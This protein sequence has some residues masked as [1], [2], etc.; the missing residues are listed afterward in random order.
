MLTS[1]KEN[2]TVVKDITDE[3]AKTLD[4]AFADATVLVLDMEAV[5]LGR[6]GNVSLVSIAT[7]THCYLFD[8]LDC[9]SITDNTICYLKRL[10]EDE[11]KK[12]VVHDCRMDSD[13]LE[14]ICKVRIKN[15]HDTSCFHTVLHGEK[16]VNLNNLLA[17][18]KITKNTV[19]DG[20][21]Y[22]QNHAFWA[23]RPLTDQMIEW[24]SN[25]VSKLFE[26]YDAQMQQA[27]DGETMSKCLAMTEH[28]RTFAVNARIKEIS[29][30]N[31]GAF[32]GRGGSNINML[33]ARTNT[34]IYP[35]G[36]RDQNKMLVY[37]QNEKDF[38]QVQIAAR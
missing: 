11:S 13:A 1:H 37:Y 10:L 16:E 2:V 14:H 26:V 15:V 3:D 34:C 20:N 4:T 12:K 29:V 32:I 35:R 5:D 30:R 8:V 18:H 24:A 36:P 25:D 28:Y 31:I 21:V 7:R 22:K 19:R 17:Y 38:N 23:T 6:E 33:R 9:T 27:Q